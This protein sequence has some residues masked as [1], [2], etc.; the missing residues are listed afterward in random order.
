MVGWL[1]LGALGRGLGHAG[2]TLFSTG[3]SFAVL[4]RTERAGSCVQTRQLQKGF[5]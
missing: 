4:A 2:P 5:L 1:G 3:R